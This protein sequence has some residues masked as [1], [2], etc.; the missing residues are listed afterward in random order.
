MKTFDLN[1]Y[2]LLELSHEEMAIIDGGDLWDFI[3]RQY[4]AFKQGLVDGYNGK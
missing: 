1:K 2:D 4:K 3:E